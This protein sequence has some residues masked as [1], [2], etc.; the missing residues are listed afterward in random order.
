[1]GTE[2][3]R[4][5]ERGLSTRSHSEKGGVE[6]LLVGQCVNVLRERVVAPGHAS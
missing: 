1:M 3:G 2:L 4:S 5:S 6:T